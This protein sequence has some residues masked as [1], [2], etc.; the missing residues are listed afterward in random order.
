MNKSEKIILAIDTA[1]EV[2]GVGIMGQ[3]SQEII[4][5]ASIDAHRSSNEKLLAVV[6]SLS[7]E[8]GVSQQDIAAVVCGRGPGSFTGVRIGVATAKGIA[9]GLG[10]PLYGVSSSDAI[11][12]EA[13]SAG[14]MGNVAVIIDAMRKEIY[15]VRYILGSEE[16]KRLDADTVAKPEDV[17]QSLIRWR[18]EQGAPVVLIGSGYEKYADVFS[19]LGGQVGQATGQTELAWQAVT[20][21]GLLLAYLDMLNSKAPAST[22][23]RDLLPVYTRLSDAEENERKGALSSAA[24]KEIS[25][26]PMSQADIQEVHLIERTHFKD[27]SWST[28]QFQDEFGRKDRTWWVSTYEEKVIGYAG[29]MSVDGVLQ[30]LKIA[31]HPDF[32]KQGIAQTLFARVVE[33][34][35]Y[36]GD[37]LIHLEVRKSNQAA[38][39][40]Y[41][42]QGLEIVGERGAY[43]PA[44]VRG[45][46]REDALI[47][48]AKI[49]EVWE[50]CHHRNAVRDEC[51]VSEHSAENLLF[52]IRCRERM[53]H[54]SVTP[55]SQHPLI[56]A[57]ETSCDETAAA[58]LDGKHEQLSNVISTQI[59]FH[60]RF[61]G[62]VPEIASRKHTEAIVDVTEV[63]LE[64]ANIT[65]LEQLDAIAITQ[66]PGLIGAL[67]V[68]VAFAKGLSWASGI[69]LL[70][71]NHL[72]GHI[73]ANRLSNPDIKPPFIT[74][75]L[76][77]GHTMIVHVKDWGNYEVLGQTLDDAVGEAYDKVAKALGLGYPGGPIISELSKTGNPKAI[78]FPR[79]LLRSHEFDFSLSGLKTAV[80]TYI[81]KE[82][83]AARKLNLNDLAASFQAAVI[84][85]QVAKA[86]KAVELTG[87]KT[88]C[89]GGG[90]AANPELRAA[91]KKAMDTIGVKSTFPELADCTDNA[92]MIAAAA[93]FY[94]PKGDFLDLAADAHA[95]FPLP[96]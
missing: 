69:P 49:D 55:A 75:L 76:S 38:I 64:K 86:I 72:E 63:A 42:K 41:E 80:V 1:T 14:L 57:I 78:D 24:S 88:Y 15:P 87:V 21:K 94:Y 8:N 84:E 30:L 83:K 33:D 12:W 10:V 45:G 85:V 70:G 81:D 17:A 54:S 29:A 31:V 5:S 23:P 90:V 66:G 79:A 71:I 34:G 77:G 96:K 36:L 89:I 74:S 28:Q 68:G 56:L 37:T 40:F 73:F 60:A 11:A 26:R 13:W 62:V 18:E 19:G 51:G 3:S 47:M 53:P 58:V 39:E 35:A 16:C 59:D 52:G 92:L 7:R 91:M 2:I 32:L 95:N 48:Q 65:K 27:N 82:N 67:V 61:G 25:T 43:Y 93:Q 50:K 6:D 22:H 20:G 9:M 46:E 4:A 44:R